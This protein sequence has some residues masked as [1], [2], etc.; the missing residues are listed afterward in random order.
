MGRHQQAACTTKT[1]LLAELAA[2]ARCPC[3]GQGRLPVHDVPPC[4]ARLITRLYGEIVSLQV[5][6]E[7]AL[8]P[9]GA[10]PL[11]PRRGTQGPAAGLKTG[12]RRSAEVAEEGVVNVA[13]RSGRSRYD[14]SGEL[15]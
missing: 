10:Q 15:T 4:A 8:T 7:D 6:V 12:T 9:A 1:E 11:L 14:R 5:L 3:S 2:N 13:G